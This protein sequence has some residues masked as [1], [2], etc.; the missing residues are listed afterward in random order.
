MSKIS[1][2]ERA[3]SFEFSSGLNIKPKKETIESQEDMPKEFRISPHRDKSS[4]K[5]RDKTEKKEKKD[6]REKRY[7]DIQVLLKI[8]IKCTKL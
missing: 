4:K 5:K 8:A 6:K 1:Y 2:E 7:Y 3:E